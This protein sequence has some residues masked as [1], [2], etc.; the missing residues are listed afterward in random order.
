MTFNRLKGKIKGIPFVKKGMPFFIRIG[1]EVIM[2]GENGVAVVILAAGMGTRMKSE[3]AKVLHEIAGKS[4]LSYVLDTALGVT[5]CEN[6]IVVIGCQAEAVRAEAMKKADV[7]FAHQHQQ[8]GTGHAVLC[9]LDF[10]PHQVEDVVI[11][12]GDVP[13]ISQQT[14]KG[15]IGKRRK[16]GLS[17]SLLTVK[18]Q[19]PTGY[20]RIIF[21]HNDKVGRIVEESDASDAEKA[22]KIVNAGTYCV[23]KTFL[24]WALTQIKSDNM[25]KELYL[26]DIV[27]IAGKTAQPAGALIIED[28]L[29]VMGVNSVQ[30]LE[31][32]ERSLQQKL[33]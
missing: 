13:F 11:L 17:V 9:A 25:Q 14:I 22:I 4:M 23:E 16:E 12:C 6:I 33:A 30:D 2:S 27:G 21:N 32:A 15:L 7:V 28:A 18:L 1:K 3:K 5:S 26:T 29:E 19:S 24:A 8:M 10:I 31:R 20:G